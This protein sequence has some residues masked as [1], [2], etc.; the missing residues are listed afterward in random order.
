MIPTIFRHAALAAVMLFVSSIAA[1]A[2]NQAVSTWRHFIKDRHDLAALRDWER[3]KILNEL[4]AAIMADPVGVGDEIESSRGAPALCQYV[5]VMFADGRAADI[6]NQLDAV[7][8]WGEG[9]QPIR[10]MLNVPSYEDGST[11]FPRAKRAGYFTGC[12]VG[13]LDGRRKGPGL[14]GKMAWFFKDN[15]PHAI[16]YELAERLDIDRPSKEESYGKWILRELSHQGL[17]SPAALEWFQLGF[18]RSY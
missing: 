4:G 7:L 17:V 9:T 18:D 13:A 14:I 12:V 10:E 11:W 1:M 15:R 2:Q 16:A 5:R 8:H 6:A 3:E